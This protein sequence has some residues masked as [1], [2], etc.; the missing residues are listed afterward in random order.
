[1]HPLWYTHLQKPKISGF[2]WVHPLW[3]THIQRPLLNQN[4]SSF[5][6][7]LSLVGT[8][9][10][11][12][13]T[14]VMTPLFW[15]LLSFSSAVKSIAITQHGV[16]VNKYP[17]RPL[18]L[19]C[20]CLATLDLLQIFTDVFHTLSNSHPITSRLQNTQHS[21]A[22]CP[23]L[24]T[25]SSTLCLT[26]RITNW[27]VSYPFAPLI[28]LYSKSLTFFNFLCCLGNLMKKLKNSE[29]HSYSL[30]LSF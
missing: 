21:L 13:N 12:V 11:L 27:R 26:A 15:N 1:M 24:W 28:L 10:N 7:V 16:G 20:G 5:R 3:Y 22:W 4:L 2:V 9:V 6:C 18:I 29:T 17:V 19:I 14:Y 25:Y 30:S 8:I 23:T